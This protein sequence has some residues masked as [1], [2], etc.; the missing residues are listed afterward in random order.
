M[1]D[2]KDMTCFMCQN[3]AINL[4]KIVLSSM[5][6]KQKHFSKGFLTELLVNIGQ[7]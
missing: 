1:V 3:T 6:T 7:P 2:V 5:L 4:N